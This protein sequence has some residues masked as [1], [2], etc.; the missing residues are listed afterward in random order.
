MKKVLNIVLVVSLLTSLFVGCG[1]K[2][3]TESAAGNNEVKESTSDENTKEASEAGDES[4]KEAT[5]ITVW[6]QNRHDLAYMEE[7]IALFNTTNTDNIYIDYITQ[8]DNY[9]NML[10]MSAS[11]DQMPDVFSHIK[12]VKSFAEAD[13]IQP[14]DEYFTDEFLAVTN[15]D[16][17]KFT[18]LNVIDGKTYYVPTG[19][20]SGVRLIY[21]K[22][23]FASAGVEVPTTLDELVETAKIITE[24]GG[25]V[26]YGTVI[27][28]LSAPI[29]RMFLPVAETSG[30]QPYD[31][32]NGVYNFDGYKPVIEAFRKLYEDGSVLPGAQSM[33]VDP[34]RVQFSEGN[35][36][37]YGN[38]SQEV[39][40][41][42]T[43]FPA[44]E[45][46]GA[47]PMPAINGEVKGTLTASP[48]LGWMLSNNTQHSEEAWKVIEFFSS[49]AFLK[50]YIES[51]L[52]LPIGEY[53]QGVVDLSNTGKLADFLPLSYEGVNP[54]PPQVT[55]EGL[56]FN[57][58]LWEACIPGG[59]SADE[60]IAELNKSYNE[61]LD[62]DVELGKVKRLIIKDF[63]LMNPQA[64]TF[65]YLDK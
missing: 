44:K 3:T 31:Y 6:S 38:A 1:T 24:Q 14:L 45:E 23:I 32:V 58:A 25:G 41:L 52:N 27:P 4:N 37:F 19:I 57:D 54:V 59:P 53:M 62:K 42:T 17:L 16:Q 43:Q 21:N 22:E 36:G 28:G 50:G 35:V 13:L 20:R 63:D 11:S 47:A 46:W 65:E 9:E 12:D 15:A 7:Q 60:V 56:T 49:E 55:P 10:M 34:I 2:E 8:T 39:G 40:V 61:A 26:D 51:G 64:G 48:N 29:V 5:T 33:K 18:D 30:I